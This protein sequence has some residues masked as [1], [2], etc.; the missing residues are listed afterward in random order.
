MVFSLATS[1]ENLQPLHC[2]P[3]LRKRDPYLYSK[4]GIGNIAMHMKAISIVPLISREHQELISMTG[5][6]GLPGIA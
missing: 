3:I 4:K 5:V 2:I 6:L 1:W